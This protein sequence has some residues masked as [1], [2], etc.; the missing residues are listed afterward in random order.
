MLV[1]STKYRVLGELRF[2]GQA[3]VVGPGGEI[4][5]RTWAKAGIATAEL[6]VAVEIAKARR[7]CCTSTSASPA[8]T[9]SADV[10]SLSVRSGAGP[11]E[12]AEVPPAATFR[13]R[14]PLVAHRPRILPPLPWGPWGQWDWWVGET[15]VDSAAHLHSTK[16]RGSVVHTLALA[17]ALADTG[18]RVAGVGVGAVAGITTLLSSVDPRVKDLSTLPPFPDIAGEEFGPRVLRSIQALR[19]AFDPSSTTWCMRRTASAPTPS[20]RCVRTVHHLDHFTTP[21]LAACH[22]PRHRQPDA[23]V[24]VRRPRSRLSCSTGGLMMAYCH[25]ERGSRRT[26]RLARPVQAG[27]CR[28]GPRGGRRLGRVRARSGRPKIQLKGVTGAAWRPRSCCILRD[29]RT[30]GPLIA[31]GVT[32][33]DYQGTGL[34]MEAARERGA[35]G[36]SRLCLDRLNPRA[37]PALVA[38][39]GGVR[40]PLDQGGLR[41]GRDGGAGRGSPVRRVKP[42]GVPRDLHRR[43]P[44]RSTTRPSWR[45]GWVPRSPSPTPMSGQPAA[46]SPP[47]TPGRQPPRSG[48]SSSTSALPHCRPSRFMASRGRC[49]AGGKLMQRGDHR[50]QLGVFAPPWPTSPGGRRRRLAGPR[51]ASS[52]GLR[53]SV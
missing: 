27:V 13:S 52:P 31:G 8:S 4:L 42:A 1:S 48:T 33:F 50:R 15:I 17:E 25:L 29:A 18:Q 20:N 22:E 21:E 10:M 16:P 37:L 30:Y 28:P 32:L 5:A 46:R 53:E 7:V 6:D 38:A 41:V 24:W 36:R 26:G 47:A 44:L 51:P 9:G 45:R 35:A 34:S 2:L 49:G 3:K 39:V 19:D 40:L 14:L 11:S 43:R 12:R 23:H